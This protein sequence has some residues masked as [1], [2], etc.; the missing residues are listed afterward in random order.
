[1]HT[2]LPWRNDGPQIFK[3]SDGWE[4]IEYGIVSDATGEVVT[5]VHTLRGNER[6]EADAAFIVRACNLH[7]ELLEMC[8]VLVAEFETG[9]QRDD[10]AEIRG[11]RAL[12]ARAEAAH[13]PQ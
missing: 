8:K 10:G 9:S 5:T 12:I 4:F 7:D 3:R 6:A 13:Q 2:P 11:A 1:M